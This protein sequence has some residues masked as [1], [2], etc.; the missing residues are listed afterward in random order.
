M[1]IFQGAVSWQ[2]PATFW[3]SL[4]CRAQWNS[5]NFRHGSVMSVC[6][7]P[8]SEHDLRWYTSVCVEFCRPLLATHS[9]ISQHLIGWQPGA[10]D[11]MKPCLETKSDITLGKLLTKL[12]HDFPE[13]PS[14]PWPRTHFRYILTD[15]LQACFNVT[16]NKLW[17]FWRENSWF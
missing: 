10:C 14:I 1:V 11:R 12:S 16:A 7:D 6:N 9:V 3:M 5:G 2:I 4:P 15:Q 8:Y 17:M 13:N